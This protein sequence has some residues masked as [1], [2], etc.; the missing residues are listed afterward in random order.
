MAVPERKTS[1]VRELQRSHTLTFAV[2]LM[3]LAVSLVSSGYLI[4]VSQPRVAGY[5]EMTRDSRDGTEAMLDQETGLRGWLATG[6]PVF[7]EPYTAGKSQAEQAFGDLSAASQDDDA[8]S[9]E[10]VETLAARDGWDARASTAAATM[11][12]EDQRVN[13]ERPTSCWRASGCS[14]SIGQR[15]R[16]AQVRSSPSAPR[17]W[18]PRSWRS[19][20]CWPATWLC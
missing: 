9:S 16:T 5:V 1:L 15:T 19:T 2:L 14:T 6:D 12:S 4:L 20:P 13:G 11:V 10:V 7:L 17:P 8:V 18:R 3:V